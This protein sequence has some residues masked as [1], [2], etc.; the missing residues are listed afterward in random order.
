MSTS[1]PFPFPLE[2]ED[3]LRR[4][5]AILAGLLARDAGF[6]AIPVRSILPSTLG[7]MLRAYDGQFFCGAL[8][9][10]F[11]ELRVT[12][13]SRLTSAAGKFVYTRAPGKG[14][15]QTEI[16]MSSDFLFRLNEGPFDL[17]GLR[18][19]TPQ[20]AFLVVFEHELC[21]AAQLA[22]DG[23]TG[24]DKRFCALALGLFGH[25]QTRHALPTRR[26]EA[27]QA[28]FRVGAEVCFPFE[29]RTLRGV[30]TYV[31]KTATVMVRAPRGPYRDSAG[32]QYQKYR[33]P[34]GLLQKPQ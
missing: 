29:E 2:P 34:V 30:L 31:G 8:L 7:R 10:A 23:H 14:P 24:H 19:A 4:R 13:S 33:V 12:L 27:A 15:G 26:T 17:N 21:H 28:G 22:L 20:E 25:T 1:L 16:R 32:R 5:A 3:I 9:H 6:C 18:V 11:P